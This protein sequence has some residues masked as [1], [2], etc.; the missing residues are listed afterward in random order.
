MVEMISSLF[1]PRTAALNQP[2]RSTRWCSV[3]YRREL[4]QRCVLNSTQ[5]H[6]YDEDDYDDADNSD[7]TV[8]VAI[9]VA[10]EA[11]TEAAKQENDEDNDKYE[12]D[13]HE[14]SPPRGIELSVRVLC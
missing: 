9:A 3:C 1:A 11:A 5:D 13:R 10:A 4:I 14:L 7:A 8:S 2:M 6:E 12:S